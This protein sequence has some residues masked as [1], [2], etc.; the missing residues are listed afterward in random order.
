MISL[1]TTGCSCRI[2]SP[3]QSSHL[4]NIPRS[5]PLQSQMLNLVLVVDLCA[6]SR[7]VVNDDLRETLDLREDGVDVDVAGSTTHQQCLEN[8]K[9]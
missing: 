9:R 4:A 8:A 6:K 1:G 2:S 5:F 3:L 7:A